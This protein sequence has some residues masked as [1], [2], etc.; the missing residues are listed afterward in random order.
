[1]AKTK[2]KKPVKEV[3]NSETEVAR[4]E[5]LIDKLHDIITQLNHETLDEQRKAEKRFLG[6]Q[7]KIYKLNQRIDKIVSAHTKCKSLKNL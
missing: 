3:C 1:M 2:K 7:Q 4:L 5:A 6:N